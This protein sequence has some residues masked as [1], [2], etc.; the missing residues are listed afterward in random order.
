M[1]KRL[2]RDDEEFQLWY[3]VINEEL[4]VHVHIYSFNKTVLRDIKET[5]ALL[6]IDAYFDGW[7]DVFTYTED[8]RIVRLV[9]GGA[10]EVGV[11]DPK[12]KSLG[13]RMFKWVLK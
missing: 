8:D 3:E 5:F 7:E 11:N 6:L 12:L 1:S 13:L 2:Y 10:I 9:G 4:F